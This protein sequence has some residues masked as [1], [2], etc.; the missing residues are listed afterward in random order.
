MIWIRRRRTVV[1]L[2]L[3]IVAAVAA[4]ATVGWWLWNPATDSPTAQDT[5]AA[6]ASPTPDESAQARAAE[7][8]IQRLPKAL[9]DGD[10][11]VLSSAAR[12]RGLAVRQA[13]PPDAV[14]TFDPATWRRTGAL[15]SATVTLTAP[16]QQPLRFVVVMIRED[17]DW[18]VSN[19]YEIGNP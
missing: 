17:D 9:A 13:L 6:G 4:A 12:E 11:G 3:A 19:T 1:W 2:C 15:G 5:G 16:G 14:L 10:D 7:A 8:L 18:K